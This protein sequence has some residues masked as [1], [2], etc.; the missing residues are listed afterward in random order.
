MLA[1]IIQVANI[2]VPFQSPI[3]GQIC[4]NRSLNYLP[5]GRGYYKFQSPKSGQICLNF[6]ILA[7]KGLRKQ[8]FQSP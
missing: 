4:L 6:L 8:G 1:S 7:K 3:A 5:Q 2:T